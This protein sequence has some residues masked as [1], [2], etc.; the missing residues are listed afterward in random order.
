[1]LKKI[2]LFILF[3][4]AIIGLRAQQKMDLMSELTFQK[5]NSNDTNYSSINYKK[6]IIHAK[7]PLFSISKAKFS[8]DITFSPVI[9]YQEISLEKANLCRSLFYISPRI[10]N[11][12]NFGKNIIH[13]SLHP[14][15]AEDDR[16]INDARWNISASGLYTH[17]LKPTLSLQGGMVY[18]TSIQNFRFLPLLGLSW[19]YSKN[20]RLQ[21]LLPFSINIEHKHERPFISQF[22]LRLNASY[23]RI[24]NSNIG[25]NSINYLNASMLK[26]T[27]TFMKLSP[28]F[29]WYFRPELNF[30]QRWTI[31]ENGNSDAVKETYY[32]PNG[33]S[34]SFG[35]IFKPL[36]APAS[37]SGQENFNSIL[38]LF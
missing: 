29:S 12:F 5:T 32:V 30:S 19:H 1:M 9:R 2:V 18:T 34:F 35:I 3:N 4:S 13:L 7:L 15:I 25:N 17:Q 31:K 6:W 27:Y 10:I 24:F 26:L 28:K 38:D 8:N 23:N 21:V 14:F 33:L 16:T 11:Q 20:N 22:T 37:Q 36:K